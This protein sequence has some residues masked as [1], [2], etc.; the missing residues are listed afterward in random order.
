MGMS[1]TVRFA[2]GFGLATGAMVPVLAVLIWVAATGRAP[3]MAMV[4][5]WAGLPV[6]IGG[7]G[8]MAASSNGSE[9]EVRRLAALSGKGRAS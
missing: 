2:V 9:R 7:A 4:A 5:V 3:G 6:A 8:L 1:A